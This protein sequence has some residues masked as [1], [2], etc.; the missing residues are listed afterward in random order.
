MSI[1]FKKGFEKYAA[2]SRSQRDS[3]EDEL[4]AF[5]KA[6]TTLRKIVPASAKGGAQVGAVI[7]AIA[8]FVRAFPAYATGLVRPSHAAIYTGVKALKGAAIGLAAGGVLGALRSRNWQ[9]KDTG[10]LRST[11]DKQ[12][13]KTVKAL[14]AH[15][16]GDK[17]ALNRNYLEYAKKRNEALEEERLKGLGTG[18]AF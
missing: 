2:L 13:V 12:L 5:N 11:T 9:R 17:D 18:D 1:N 14:R 10:Y 8:S 4:H 15:K 7:G 6:E 16:A 3:Y